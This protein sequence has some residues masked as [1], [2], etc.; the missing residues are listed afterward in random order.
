MSYKIYIEKKDR[1]PSAKIMVMEPDGTLGDWTGPH[2]L[3]KDETISQLIKRTKDFF[4][5][6]FTRSR[7]AKL[8]FFIVSQNKGKK[9][10]E[11][12]FPKIDFSLDKQ[13]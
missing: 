1:T 6:K 4:Y 11:K 13:Y 2:K 5:D 8:E 3:R 7:Y 9:K 10:I 12:I